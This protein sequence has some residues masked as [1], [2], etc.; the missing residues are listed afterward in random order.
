[1]LLQAKTLLL[2]VILLFWMKNSDLSLDSN[3]NIVQDDDMSWC[4]IPGHRDMC[5]RVNNGSKLYTLLWMEKM[6]T[7]ETIHQ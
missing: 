4:S 7:W 5:A 6:C 2:K 1:M 3:V